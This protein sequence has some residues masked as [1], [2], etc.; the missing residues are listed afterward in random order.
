MAD[1][2]IFLWIALDLF[3][4]MSGI[5]VTT[6]Y[7]GRCGHTIA[8]CPECA[9]PLEREVQGESVKRYLT[10][11][12]GIEEQTAT[13]L[14][15]ARQIM[16]GAVPFDSQ[17]MRKL[18]ELVQVVRAVI[19]VELKAHRGLTSKDLPVV[20]MGVASI[21]PVFTGLDGMAEVSEDDLAWPARSET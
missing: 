13:Q 8:T 16:H 6:H 18:G 12:F 11:R 2:F 10:S 5:G 14:W 20:Q 19:A 1:Q 3:R 15:K 17:V 21:N 9:E 7:R 4:G